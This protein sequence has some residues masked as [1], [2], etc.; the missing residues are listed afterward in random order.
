MKAG[1]IMLDI[2]PKK[3]RN[4]RNGEMEDDWWGTGCK[5]MK[6]NNFFRP[7]WNKGKVKIALL[8]EKLT[9]LKE[10]TNDPLL[11]YDYEGDSSDEDDAEKSEDDSMGSEPR[12]NFMRLLSKWVRKVVEYN[13]M[14]NHFAPKEAEESK[15]RV[16]YETM[17]A[18][19]WEARIAYRRVFSDCGVLVNV[20]DDYRLEL[21]EAE[22]VLAVTSKPLRVAE[23]LS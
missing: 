7:F 13:M 2:A 16:D 15:L 19:L 3:K 9:M 22:N 17:D 10:F 14:K 20:L 8:D 11:N 23:L 5:T 18:N 4:P 21:S 6:T 1:C 12:Y